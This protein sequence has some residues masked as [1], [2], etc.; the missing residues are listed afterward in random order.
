[1]AETSELMKRPLDTDDLTTKRAWEIIAPK[2]KKYLG[3]DWRESEETHIREQIMEVLSDGD[4]GYHM[5]RELERRHYWEEDRYLVD[6]MDDASFALK[7]A[8]NE[9]VKQWIEV[10]G[11]SPARAIGDTVSTTHAYRK[12]QI[13][14]IAQIYLDDAKYGVHFTDQP[15]TSWQILNYEEV[16]D[17]PENTDANDKR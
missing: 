8:H 12:G 6:L 3:Q 1:M 15:K 16:I 5:A 9:L 7:S 14:T 2:V 17:V 13:G 4:D 11:I 10:Y